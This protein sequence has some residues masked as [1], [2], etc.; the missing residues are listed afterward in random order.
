MVIY[1]YKLSKIM[2]IFKDAVLGFLYLVS[3]KV[4]ED[5]LV[6]GAW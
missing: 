6:Q 4:E 2:R 3:L 5:L 1:P